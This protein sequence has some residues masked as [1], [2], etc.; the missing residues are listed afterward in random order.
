[1]ENLEEMIFEMNKK[2]GELD[3]K[4]ELMLKKMDDVCEVNQ[5]QNKRIDI[6]EEKVAI[7]STYFRIIGFV[8]TISGTIVAVIMKIKG[9]FGN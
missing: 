7:H 8:L 3:G 4:M 6:L 1:M 5:T 2:I 9:V